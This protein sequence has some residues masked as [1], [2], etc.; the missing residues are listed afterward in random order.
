MDKATINSYYEKLVLLVST[1]F[2]RELLNA[3]LNN[4]LDTDNKLRFNNFACGI[5]ELSRHVLSSLAP[6][7]E[8]QNCEWYKNETKKKGAASRGEKIKYAIQ[9]GLSDAYVKRE[10]FDIEDYKKPVLDSID[11]LSKYTHVNE[12]TFNL[13]DKEVNELSLTVVSAFSNFVTAIKVFKEELIKKL[14]MH[15]DNAFIEHSI[16]ESIDDIDILST[17]HNI[18]EIHPSSVDITELNSKT[19]TLEVIGSIEVR[20]Q[21]GSDGDLS[22]GDGLEMYNSFPFESVLTIEI[23]KKFPKSKLNIETFTVNT[24]DWYE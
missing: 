20:Q 3:C 2:Q 16:T 14:E 10:F 1:D 11:L 23:T 15:I 24:D 6:D 22:R 8:V 9:G 12:A 4:L 17:H 21:W 19:I 5:R 13:R 7:G 18:E